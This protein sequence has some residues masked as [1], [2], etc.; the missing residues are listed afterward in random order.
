[1]EEALGFE[2]LVAS[3]ASVSVDGWDFSCFD[4]R[5]TEERPPWGYSRRLVERIS[6]AGA[7]LDVQ[8]GGGE[9]LAVV[10]TQ[11]R[12]K[13]ESF[14]ATESWSPNLEIARRNLGPFGGSV[15][16]VADDARLSFD[17]ESFDLMVSRHPVVVIW[18]EIARVLRPG[19]LYFS[20]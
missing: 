5:A 10:M 12:R 19:G 7:V 15:I 14:A 6:G 16:E 4:G 8:T 11:V 17:G 13:P 20:Q 18:D 2:K 3:A 9:V 1:V